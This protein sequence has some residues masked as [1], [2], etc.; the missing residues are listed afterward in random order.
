M[1]EINNV[2]ILVCGVS[3]MVLGA[4]WYSPPVFGRVWQ[5]AVGLSDEAMA[6]GSMA[7]I[8]GLA[9]VLSLAAALAVSVLLGPRPE[10]RP[11]IA[12]STSIGLFCVAASFGISYLF[13]RRRLSLWLINGGYHVAQFTLFGLILGL[14]G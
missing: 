13:E 4:I 5:R 1:P 3:S 8:F 10:L 9:F 11:A 6:A 2:A 7:M 12:I 14:L